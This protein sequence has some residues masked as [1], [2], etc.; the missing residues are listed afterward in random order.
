MADTAKKKVTIQAGE[1]ELN[2]DVG[3]G[4]FNKF[5]NDF[6]PQNKVAP[7]EN[8]LTACIKKG[9]EEALIDLCDKGLSIELASLVAAEFKPEIEL[10]VKK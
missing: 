7:S 5:Q 8:F 6:L 10:T 3:I 4:A 2:F 9:Q 1:T